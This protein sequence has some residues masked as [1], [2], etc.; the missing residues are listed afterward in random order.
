[1]Q[2]K[3]S[4]SRNQTPVRWHEAT[5]QADKASSPPPPT[6]PSRH[7]LGI[8][9]SAKAWMSA[10]FSRLGTRQVQTAP[11]ATAEPSA[12]RSPSSSGH[13]SRLLQTLSPARSTPASPSPTRATASNST[14]SNAIELA[15]L[16]T[17]AVTAPQRHEARLMGEQALARDRAN[18][19]AAMERGLNLTLAQCNRAMV[20]QPASTADIPAQ[21]M[22]D[23]HRGWD[24]SFQSPTGVMHKL[25]V[26][27]DGNARLIEQATGQART[28]DLRRGQNAAPVAQ[29]AQAL[30]T[31]PARLLRLCSLMAQTELAYAE[32]VIGGDST[33]SRPFSNG[34][35]V[36]PM[37]GERVGVLVLL[38]AEGEEDRIDLSCMREG[39]RF[40]SVAVTDPSGGYDPVF[41]DTEQS[42]VHWQVEARI[43]PTGQATVDPAGVRFDYTLVRA[44]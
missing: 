10:K 32:T 19:G 14:A 1:M 8:F 11:A 17:P 25:R 41:L 16:T 3:T 34:S 38:G 5:P 33:L 29:L 6:A 9:A 13:W 31:S 7:S 28:F 36:T 40:T 22:T 30:G 15:T 12:S 21:A 35:R 37:G 43:S 39:N 2:P 42:F 20:S 4:H 23:W 27:S 24:M 26:A 44:D 18:I